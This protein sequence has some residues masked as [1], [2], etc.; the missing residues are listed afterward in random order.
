MKSHYN[1]LKVIG[2]YR[3]I[4]QGNPCTTQ[5]PSFYVLTCY[6]ETLEDSERFQCQFLPSILTFKA[7]LA[8]FREWLSWIF[9]ERACSVSSLIVPT[10][11]DI[12]SLIRHHFWQVSALLLLVS[13]SAKE[14]FKPCTLHLCT[15]NIRQHTSHWQENWSYFAVNFHA[16]YTISL[17]PRPKQG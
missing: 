17:V 9:L 12:N 8:T 13:I 14:L 10:T 1:H 4:W 5:C 6:L 3:L 7:F 15:H 16:Y 11:P 2:R